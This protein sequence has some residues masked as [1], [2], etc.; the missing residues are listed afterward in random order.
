MNKGS[1]LVTGAHGY[2]GSVLMGELDSRGYRT[3]GVDNGLMSDVRVPLRHG[4]YVD[5]DIRE[6]AGWESLLADVDAVVHLA[7]IV[8]DPACGLDEDLA[9]QTNYLAT[10]GLTEACRRYGVRDFFFASTCSNYGLSF[11]EAA[12]LHTAL[13][14]QSVYAESK[15]Y[16]E[17]H[18][19]SNA[20]EDF[21]PRIL[22]LSTLYGL[23]PRMRFDLSINVMTAHAVNRGEVTVNGGAQWRPFLHVR[24]AAEAFIR[25]IEAKPAGALNVWN[26]GSAAQN[27]RIIDIAEII[28]AEVPGTRIARR[29]ADADSRDYLVDFTGMGEDLGFEPSRGV[30]EEVRLLARAVGGGRF[31]PCT[32]TEFSNYETLRA[33][34][35]AGSAARPS[36][37]HPTTAVRLAHQGH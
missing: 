35:Y 27:H 31:G 5:A 24:D 12:G 7:A 1:V 26:C 28:A 20:G 3:V 23:S 16:S 2:L 10:V 33:L 9:W 13:H 29:E 11:G 34:T 37:G 8:G 19:L 15:I 4:R 21:R 25:A 30:A 22:R 6:P 17:H 18:L 14:P 36:T 32:G